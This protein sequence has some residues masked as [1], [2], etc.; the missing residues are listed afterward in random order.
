MMPMPWGR[1]MRAAYGKVIIGNI[2]PVMVLS[3]L[4]IMLLRMEGMGSGGEGLDVEG[5]DGDGGA[6]ELVEAD[7][8]A[9]CGG[10]GGV[11]GVVGG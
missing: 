3:P 6:A 5:G 7:E 10:V 2:I 11:Y 9:G 4:S 8:D 1:S